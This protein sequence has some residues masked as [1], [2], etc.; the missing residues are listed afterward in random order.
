M[1]PGNKKEKVVT[2]NSREGRK[3]FLKSSGSYSKRGKRTKG[4]ER[5][6]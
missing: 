1:F 3:K 6:M 5:K 4:G 2:L